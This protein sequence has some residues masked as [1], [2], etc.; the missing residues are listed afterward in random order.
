[1]DLS[2]LR[3]EIDNAIAAGRHGSASSSLAEL[4][5]K[6]PSSS[7]A[8]F[9]ISRYEALSS[10]LALKPYRLAI[11]RS[12]TVEPVVPLLRAGAFSYGID[13]SVRVGDFNAYA[14]EIL[15]EHSALYA[16]KPD[17]V[18]LAVQTCDIAPDLWQDFCSLGSEAVA[19]GV[20]RVSQSFRDCVHALRRH[21]NA[22]LVIHGLEQPATPQRGIMDA[23]AECSQAHAIQCINAEIRRLAAAEKGVYFLDYDGL[24]ARYGREN[25]RD[26]RKWL[27]AR[28]PLAAA[29]LSHF[30]R[31]WLRFLLPL[32][33][34]VAKVA[35]VDLDNTLWGG[36]IGEDGM[37]GIQLGSEYPGAAYQEFQRALLDLSQRGILLAA[38]S[39]NN[40]DD[41]LEALEKHPGMLLRPKH[42]AALR[43]NWNDKAQGLREI[44]GELN[45]GIDAVAFADDNPAERKHVRAALPEVAVIELPDDPM[46]FAAAL[47][48][49]PLFERLALSEE[50]RQ[51]SS[52]YAAE[53]ERKELAQ[54]FSTKEEFYE[55]LAQEVEIAP[56]TPGTLTR[57]AQLTQ[58]TNQFNLTTRRYTEQQISELA[59]T[60]ASAVWSIR[61]RD[62]FGDNGLVGVAI[63]LDRGETCEIDTFLLSCR[64]IGRTVETAFL[65]HLLQKARE[66]QKRTMQGWFLPTKKNAPARDFYASHGFHLAKQEDGRL[67]WE[68]DLERAQVAWP[69]WIKLAGVRG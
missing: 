47:R 3:S 46:G 6:D 7:T 15:D 50:D 11:L 24:V 9:V 49:C 44:A 30:A 27:T 69:A 54:S 25:W 16:F 28:L 31:E 17:G 40:L 34:K 2:G 21:S 36:V 14:Q 67:L 23:Q 37:T 35:A 26:A 63:T 55:S 59:G 4:W 19:K 5:S 43:I 57:I 65:A 60:P 62:C 29:H 22:S 58:K 53:R 64:V 45:I 12:F 38:C 66:K 18:I 61:V 10:H 68:L 41:A 33:G 1:M 56:V 51:R 20:H 32:A 48:D 42:F 52:Y 8:G 13:L 39:K